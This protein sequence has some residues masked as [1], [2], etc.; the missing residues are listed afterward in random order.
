MEA[1]VWSSLIATI[2]KQFICKHRTILPNGDVNV[3]GLQNNRL[4]VVLT[5]VLERIYFFLKENAGRAHPKRD[6]STGLY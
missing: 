5:D 3:D 4:L 2:L 6:K 1:L